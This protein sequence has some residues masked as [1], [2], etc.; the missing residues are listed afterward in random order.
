MKDRQYP[1]LDNSTFKY[2]WCNVA[3]FAWIHDLWY[4]QLCQIQKNFVKETAISQLICT[5]RR[6]DGAWNREGVHI[7][8]ACSCSHTVFTRSSAI[9]EIL[10]EALVS[11]NPT[12][13]KTSHLK[14]LSWDIICV[15]LR[16]AILIQHRKVTD[17]HT[18]RV[19][20]DGQTHDDG[21]Y[22][23]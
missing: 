4:D 12:K 20:A 23:T 3:S 10:R 16:L 1:Q 6:L 15:I 2:L 5:Y 21:I 18:H 17:T 11:R 14:T 22:R 13:Y 8:R 9:A 7:L 19:H